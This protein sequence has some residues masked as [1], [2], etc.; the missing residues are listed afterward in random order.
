LFSNVINNALTIDLF[1]SCTHQL[2]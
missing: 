2:W 1:F